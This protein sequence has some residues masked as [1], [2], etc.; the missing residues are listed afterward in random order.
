MQMQQRTIRRSAQRRRTRLKRMEQQHKELQGSP[1]Q[2]RPQ[3]RRKHSER[4]LALFCFRNLHCPFFVHSVIAHTHNVR[5]F[6]M[7]IDEAK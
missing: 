2:M 3:R 6:G 5:I 7:F 4:A 1:P